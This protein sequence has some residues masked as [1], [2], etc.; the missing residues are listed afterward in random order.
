MNYQL[1]KKVN[2]LIIK[3]CRKSRSA[4]TEKFNYEV[5]KKVNNLH[6]TSA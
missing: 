1:L 4:K 3:L 6:E 2:N 5:I